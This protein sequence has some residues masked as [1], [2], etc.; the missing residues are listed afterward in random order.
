M[1]FLPNI[2]GE[3]TSRCEIELIGYRK[4]ACSTQL[5]AYNFLCVL[6]RG[7][8]IF[9]YDYSFFFNKSPSWVFWNLLGSWQRN[10]W[11][12]SDVH[13]HGRICICIQI[14]LSYAVTKTV[15]YL[16]YNNFI[17]KLENM[18]C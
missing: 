17:G 18:V 5:K 13:I 4:T 14:Y 11:F 3:F 7:V 15:L 12:L 9:L 8:F 10:I 1:P 2:Y 6:G 16:T